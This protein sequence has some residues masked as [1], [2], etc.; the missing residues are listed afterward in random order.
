[1][2][3]MRLAGR[4]IMDGMKKTARVA[5][6]IRRD[7]HDWSATVPAALHGIASETHALQSTP[8]KQGRQ[9]PPKLAPYP[10]V[11]VLT[12]RINE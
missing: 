8:K 10:S 5:Q 1:M 12:R 11:S 9:P 3:F 6:Y 4:R 2:V 7:Y